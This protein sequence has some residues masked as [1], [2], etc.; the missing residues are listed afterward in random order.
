MGHKQ[1]ALSK[2]RQRHHHAEAN[3]YKTE[4]GKNAV[5]TAQ[6]TA[7]QAQLQQLTNA[8]STDEAAKAKLKAQINSLTAQL[9]ADNAA[10]VKLQTEINADK[11]QITSLTTQVAA[12]AAEKNKLQTEITADKSQITNLTTQVTKDNKLLV[13][14][15]KTIG[16]LR[17]ELH[18][19]EEELHDTKNLASISLGT[20]ALYNYGSQTV[21]DHTA[22][23]ADQNQI[24]QE[25][26]S[27]INNDKGKLNTLYSSLA[28]EN[29]LL[30]SQAQDSLQMKLEGLDKQVLIDTRRGMLRNSIMKNKYNE[31]LIMTV[32]SLIFAVLIF[33][34]SVYIYHERK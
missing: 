23:L 15:T 2:S 9:A 12:D 11:S 26:S 19:A 21:G 30:Q 14:K 27:Q 29:S 16:G 34:L 25:M 1:S 13:Q 17:N 32:L 22:Q 6:L 4:E 20:V 33:I 24:L 10:N 28:Q 5:L 7:A 3:L 8:L 31:K 18:I